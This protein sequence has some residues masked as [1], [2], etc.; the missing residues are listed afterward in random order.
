MRS[1]DAL[2][3]TIY[4]PVYKIFKPSWRYCQ[5]VIG[6]HFL[7]SLACTAV[8]LTFVLIRFTVIHYLHVHATSVFLA[9]LFAQV[10]GYFMEHSWSGESLRH[11]AVPAVVALLAECAILAFP[12]SILTASILSVVVLTVQTFVFVKAYD[13]TSEGEFIS[14]LKGSLTLC[15]LLLGAVGTVHFL[16]HTAAP[17]DA[18]LSTRI[19]CILL[20]R[21]VVRL[22]FTFLASLLVCAS[23][24]GGFDFL[25]C[26]S[27]FIF[28]GYVVMD[29]PVIA[30]VLRLHPPQSFLAVVAFLLSDVL[31]VLVESR[32]APFRA[33]RNPGLLSLPRRLS[34][35]HCV[36]NRSSMSI[37]ETEPIVHRKTRKDFGKLAWKNLW[38]RFRH[39]LH[40]DRREMVYCP[41]LRRLL[42]EYDEFMFSS[43]DEVKSYEYQ[44]RR[45]TYQQ[46]AFATAVSATVAPLAVLGGP[47]MLANAA[48]LL[49]CK[50]FADL[51]SW[52]V[53]RVPEALKSI[54]DSAWTGN[55]SGWGF[56]FCAVG[57]VLFLTVRA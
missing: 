43:K 30:L 23:E 15:F 20:G 56:R 1:C 31:F 42:D 53:V 46:H 26:F 4:R 32:V 21:F 8:M 40:N 17:V 3:T 18:L 49:V 2:L 50:V 11:Y 10:A 51:F 52:V 38:V 27:D 24:Q 47:L 5:E 48:V 7:L 25:L 28:A 29:V 13:S 45:I 41:R 36:V 37:P 33:T 22:L 35:V 34:P 54:D 12:L 9:F 57:A 55:V 19:F 16:T 6:Y 44:R 14:V 39:A